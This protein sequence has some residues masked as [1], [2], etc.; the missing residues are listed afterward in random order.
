MSDCKSSLDSEKM[1][2]KQIIHLNKGMEQLTENM[3]AHN[4]EIS[5]S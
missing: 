5:N 1:Q 3:H 4:S 2:D